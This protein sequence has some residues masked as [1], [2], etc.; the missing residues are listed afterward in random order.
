[1]T[2]PR[3]IREMIWKNCVNQVFR[4]S[5]IVPIK[6]PNICRCVD[7]ETE[8]LLEHGN[9]DLVSTLLRDV[10]QEFTR[11]VFQKK[12]FRFRCCCEMEDKLS[13]NPY[14]RYHIRHVIVHWHGLKAPEAFNLLDKCPSLESLTIKLSKMT[15][16]NFCE[17]AVLVNQFFYPPPKRTLVDALGID[18]LLQ[19]RG[20]DH[21]DVKAVDGVDLRHRPAVSDVNCLR[22]L[23]YQ[24]LRLP[25]LVSEHGEKTR[26]TRQ[27]NQFKEI[28]DVDESDGDL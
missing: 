7:I 11:V 22:A 1:M 8:W 9:G 24:Q 21:V 26:S 4:G 12:K 13:K 6:Q 20:L 25:K 5:S 10:D 15:L 28:E 14:L 27:A 23:L 2:L 18:E 17:R 19:I 3:E 16:R